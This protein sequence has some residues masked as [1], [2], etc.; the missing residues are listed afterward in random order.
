MRRALHLAIVVFA[1][2]LLAKPFDCF[3]S[4]PLTKEA[5]DCC[6]KGKCA[7]TAQADDCCKA[8]VPDGNQFL[9]SKTSDHLISAFDFVAVG[10]SVG[11][12]PQLDHESLLP[13]LSTPTSPPDTRLN[14]PLL[15]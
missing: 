7:P 11:I 10:G 6:K 14:L 3:A 8:T 2:V 1:M 5:A 12:A 4:A 15:I 13:V 9:G